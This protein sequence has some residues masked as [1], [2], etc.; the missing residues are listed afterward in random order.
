MTKL[1]YTPD[2]DIKVHEEGAIR[3]LCAPFQSHEAG[4]PE[5]LKNSADAYARE[6]VP[7]H[8]RIIL[9]ILANAA[10]GKSASI[11]VVDFVGMTSTDIEGD[12]RNWAD[13]DA[14]NRAKS[15]R[16]VQGG[17]G[18]G[19]KCYMTQMFEEFSSIMT[20]REGKGNRYG[21][22]GGSIR[23]GYIPDRAS[24]RDF[25]VPDIG[26]ELLH[27]LRDVKCSISSLPPEASDAL[28]GARG[29]SLVTGVGPKGLGRQIN[30]RR[31]IQ[32]LENHPQM[33][34][35]LEMCSLYVIH[36]GVVEK[37]GKPLSLPSITPMEGAEA[38]K[39]VPIP[40]LL[41]DPATGEKVSTTKDGAL[42]EGQLVLLTSNLSMRYAG[43][44]GRHNVNYRTSSG[45]IGYIPVSELDVQSAFRDKIYGECLLESLEPFKLNERARLAS[46]PLVRAVDEFIAREVE[47]YSRS[48][49][50]RER[51][52]YDQQEKDAISK[53]NEALDQWKNRFLKEYM[54]G[55][56]GPGGGQPLPQPSLPAGKPARVEIGLSHPMAGLGVSFRPS[57]RFWD[58]G[59]REV[60]AV[61]YRWVSG[62]TNVAM[63]DED[64]RIV[65]TYSYGATAIWAESL[66]GSLKSN[67]LPIQVVEIHAVEVVPL[68]IEVAAGSRHKLEA[69]C[70]L[71]DGPKSSD[72][73]LV[74]TEAD[75]GVARVSA[76]GLVYGFT[77]GRTQVHAGDDHCLSST[78]AIVTVVPDQPAGRK[79]RRSPGLPLV[80]VSSVNTDPDTRE[81]VNLSS[82]FP[83]VWQRPVDADRNIWWI[84]SSS[85]MARLYLSKDKGY[86]FESREWRMYH[87]ER[88]IDVIAQI[89]IVNGPKESTSMSVNEWLLEWGARVSEVQLAAASDLT[90]FIATGE[91][92]TEEV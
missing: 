88:Y 33:I 80:L 84:N 26:S 14:A 89:A 31:F 92:P 77:P 83:P 73:Y 2:Q 66:E 78:P 57:I 70:T 48:F 60:R 25:G 29:F 85:P 75:S 10:R 4:L 46:A 13:P 6:D 45:Y 81:E 86:G 79:D 49:E 58:A 11:S 32:D 42:P 8:E 71:E 36:D 22:A 90:L 37:E 52:K 82:D 51:R 39:S 20:V 64:L 35:T 43:R 28:R 34:R 21:V 40:A 19:G 68:E 76:A 24:G 9:V 63:V 62:D 3:L 12:F 16:D 50:A 74:W 65:D 59:D 23:F 55:L 1:E 30:P 53:M 87:L 91:L 54:R 17:H 18:N 41:K 47:T 72:V 61:P 5:W 69:I 67:K 56:W 44:R 38:G 27:E 7:Q 15:R